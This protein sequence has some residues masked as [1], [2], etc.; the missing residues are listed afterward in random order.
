MANVHVTDSAYKIVMK[1]H[2]NINS[3]I[4][5]FFNIVTLIFSELIG[6][7]YGGGVMELIPSEFKNLPIYYQTIESKVFNS[8][9]KEFNEEVVFNNEVFEYLNL[10]E[11]E[12]VMLENIYTKLTQ[13][14][15]H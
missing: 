2:F 11:E 8:F 9:E 4:Y 12:I 13:A 10:N 7:K 14:R 6:R 3:F 5:S 1:D 15:M